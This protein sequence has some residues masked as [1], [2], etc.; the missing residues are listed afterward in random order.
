MKC[1]N[2]DYRKQN[3]KSKSKPAGFSLFPQ[4]YDDL[5]LHQYDE[6]S[7]TTESNDIKLD[8]GPAEKAKKLDLIQK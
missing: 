2:L 1:Q 3:L 7:L 5:S 4:D 6:L 8:V